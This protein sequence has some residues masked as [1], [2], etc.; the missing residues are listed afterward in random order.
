MKREE[1][2]QK[3]IAAMMA[4]GLKWADIADRVG[5]S[6]EWTT[7]ALLGHADEQGRSG[8]GRRDLRTRC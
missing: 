1:V 2:T 4:K 8:G 3:I 6:K 5:R 7:A